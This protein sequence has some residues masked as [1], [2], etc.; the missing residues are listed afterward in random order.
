MPEV[1]SYSYLDAQEIRPKVTGGCDHG[2]E[3]LI[4]VKCKSARLIW[5][6]GSSYYSGYAT[7]Y[8]PCRLEVYGRPGMRFAR[9]EVFSEG[10]LTVKRLMEHADKICELMGLPDLDVSM[11]EAKRTLVLEGVKPIPYVSEQDI[12]LKK[13]E[14]ER[15]VR[16]KKLRDATPMV[17]WILEQ[18]CM[19]AYI[20][21]QYISLKGRKLWTQKLVTVQEDGEEV[22]VDVEF[23]NEVPEDASINEE[24]HK[25][26]ARVL[27]IADRVKG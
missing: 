22:A 21:G 14:A 20:D 23:E 11:I 4:L 27:K 1:I 13:V 5:Q 7:Q 15:V 3:G 25:A 19:G 6:K 17:S 12:R 2:A 16:L 9:G 26:V 10:R 18:D 24:A 8:S